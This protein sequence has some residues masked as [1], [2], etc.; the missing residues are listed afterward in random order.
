[1]EFQQMGWAIDCASLFDTSASRSFQPG[2]S[3]DVPFAIR[4]PNSEVGGCGGTSW[5]KADA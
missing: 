1:M 3:R 4:H 2:I 5:Q